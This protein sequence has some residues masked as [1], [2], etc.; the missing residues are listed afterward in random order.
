MQKATDRV[1]GPSAKRKREMPR[2]GGA[3]SREARQGKWLTCEGTASF[4]VPCYF[5][6]GL[7]QSLRQTLTITLRSDTV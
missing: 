2:W 6:L 1:A 5:N 3:R 7:P 4:P